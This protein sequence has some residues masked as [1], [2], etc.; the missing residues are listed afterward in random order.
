MK[1]EGRVKLTCYKQDGSLKWTTGWLKNTI[2]N[3]G[4][5]AVAR[6]VGYDLGGDRFRYLAVGTN[7]AAESAA[8]T[9]LTTEL[10]DSGLARVAATVTRVTTTQTNDTLHLTHTWNVTATK[11]VEE[12]GVFD[13]S[14]AGT[15]LG[16][17]LTGSKA[18]ENGDDLKGEY[19][20]QFS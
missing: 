10:T 13:A 1:I 8:H 3:A 9:T 18:V 11:T 5:A 12:V 7:N 20:I 14:S 17:K 16:R 2:T 4:L 6:L 19:E 15:M